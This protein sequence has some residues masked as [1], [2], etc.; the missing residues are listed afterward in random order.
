MLK[1]K[2]RIAV[3]VSGG[4]TN[5]QALID[6]KAAGRLPPVE[7]V[8]VSEPTVLAYR[9]GPVLVLLNLGTSPCSV[10]SKG[11]DA[12]TYTQWLNSQTI[13]EGPSTTDVTLDANAP[14]SL[15]GKGFA[16]FVKQ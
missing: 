4:G 10:S 5:L 1:E 11:I 7:F 15:E 9:R 3:L 12:G 8:S 6:A 14:I 2:A 16:V 13:T